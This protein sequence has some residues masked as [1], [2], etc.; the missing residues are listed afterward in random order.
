MIGELASSLLALTLGALIALRCRLF[1]S[2]DPVN[3]WLTEPFE[4]LRVREDANGDVMMCPSCNATGHKPMPWRDLP[5]LR[6][7]RIGLQ[8]TRRNAAG[9]VGAR[10]A[11]TGSSL[12]A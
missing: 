5:G 6:R 3:P 2:P 7:L 4:N 9:W 8:P 10:I 12:S 11:D 1:G